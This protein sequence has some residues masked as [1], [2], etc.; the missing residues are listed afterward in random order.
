MLEGP[1]VDLEKKVALVHRLVFADGDL[2]HLAFDPGGHLNDVGLDVGVRG[3][4]GVAVRQDVIGDQGHDHQQ[5]EKNPGSCR[6]QEPPPNR[7]G[8]KQHRQ[9]ELSEP[10]QEPAQTGFG[11]HHVEYLILAAEL[12]RKGLYRLCRLKGWNQFV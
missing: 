4:R 11:I 10:T 8:R 6:K 5:N 2:D 1:A 12:W 3:E 9:Q 7:Q